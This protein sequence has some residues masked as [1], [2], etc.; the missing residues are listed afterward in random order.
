MSTS[1]NR[2]FNVNFSIDDVKK[3][4]DV[5][6]SQSR[7]Y[8]LNNKNDIFNT[9]TV[10]LV[11]GLQVIPINIQ[12]KKNSDLET[13]IVI[14]SSKNMTSAGHEMIVNKTIDSFLNLVAK[15]LSGEKIHEEIIEPK[16]KSDWKVVLIV[17]GVGGIALYILIMMLK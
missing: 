4:I 6:L 13:N 9:F 14:T 3:N 12:L 2:D 11:N 17:F 8:Q 10:T 15:S 1:I 16:D 5:V 7:S